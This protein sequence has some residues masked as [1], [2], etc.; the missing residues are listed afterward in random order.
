MP[1]GCVNNSGRLI[2]EYIS[3]IKGVT[4]SEASRY[5]LI[6]NYLS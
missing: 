5:T 1:T 6:A 3:F 2:L 4:D